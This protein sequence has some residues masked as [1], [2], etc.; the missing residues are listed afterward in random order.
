MRWTRDFAEKN[1]G[2]ISLIEEAKPHFIEDAYNRVLEDGGRVN[3]PSFYILSK[4]GVNSVKVARRPILGV[5]TE[6]DALNRGLRHLGFSLGLFTLNMGTLPTRWSLDKIARSVDIAL[7]MFSDK[8]ILEDIHAK[9][10]PESIWW[11]SNKVS[12][13]VYKDTFIINVEDGDELSP[14]AA[15]LYL[16]RPLAHILGEVFLSYPLELVD[17]G[18]GSKTIFPVDKGLKPISRI[19]DLHGFIIPCGDKAFLEILGA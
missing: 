4:S 3:L 6:E 2:T 11:L 15:L 13:G 8:S 10:M 12:A 17:V 5:L 1:L 14:V 19:E 16:A 18:Q 7:L 9:T